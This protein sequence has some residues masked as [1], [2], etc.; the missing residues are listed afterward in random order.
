MS[1]TSTNSEDLSP[2]SQNAARRVM[3]RLGISMQGAEQFLMGEMVASPSDRIKLAQFIDIGIL[4]GHYKV[5]LEDLL[6]SQ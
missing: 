3:Q 5:S 2:V 1:Q 4:Q 6:V